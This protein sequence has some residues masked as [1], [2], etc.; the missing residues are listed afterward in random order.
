VVIALTAVLALAGGTVAVRHFRSAASSS[1]VPLVQSLNVL[2]PITAKVVVSTS[3]SGTGAPASVIQGQGVYD[4]TRGRGNF[5]MSV[6]S[7]GPTAVIVNAASVYVQQPVVG[8][9]GQFGWTRL[10]RTALPSTTRLSV[11]FLD[12]ATVM[13]YL[14]AASSADPV[15]VAD[16][17]LQ[18]EMA[19]HYQA[20]LDLT[21]GSAVGQN[22]RRVA[23]NA[24]LNSLPI[25]VWLDSSSRIRKVAFAVDLSKLTVA[26]SA[27]SFTGVVSYAVEFSD[28]G[29][30]VDTQVPSDASL[31]TGAVVAP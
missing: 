12:P 21:S 24:G 15:K 1:G 23:I 17:P 29:I 16:E 27:T 10:D 14:N 18:G 5:Q 20:V 3:F 25:D 4:F 26:K 11:G 13:S 9:N 22:V 31:T 30:P 19:S 28:F 2:S 7:V 6:P 8:T